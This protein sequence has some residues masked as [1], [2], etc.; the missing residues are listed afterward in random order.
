MKKE[1]VNVV[2]ALTGLLL[3]ILWIY[4]YLFVIPAQTEDGPPGIIALSPAFFCELITILLIF[5]SFL[6]I[7]FSILHKNNLSVVE[8]TEKSDRKKLALAVASIILY[9]YLLDIIGFF[10]SSIAIML[11]LMIIFEYRK[12]IQVVISLAI[13][14]IFIYVMFFKALKVVLPTGLLI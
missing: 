3:L 9:T 7:V 4:T 12:W 11:F 8:E 14:T 6:L 10:V 5:L 2:D 13:V 1:N